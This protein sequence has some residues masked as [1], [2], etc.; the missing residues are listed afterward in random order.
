MKLNLD[1]KG[2][3]YI[4]FIFWNQIW[5]R[6]IKN[7]PGTLVGGEPSDRTFDIGA[8]RIRTIAYAQLSPRYLI[9]A[10]FGINNQTFTNGGGTVS[11]GT[12]ANG[13]GK[14]PQIFYHDVWNEYA[15][16]PSKN[17]VT[18]K[19]NKASLYAGAGLH[20]WN[21]ISRLTSASTLNFLLID[22]PLFNW[23]TL[24]ISD[25]FVRQFGFYAKGHAGKLH[26]RFNVNKPFA[27]N[28]APVAAGVAVDNNGD[29]KPAVGGYVDYQFLD[30]ENE[31]LPF[32]VG[33]YAG[34]K[35]VLNIG[36]GFYRTKDGTKSIIAENTIQKHDINIQAVDVFAD[37]P[38]GSKEK[39]MAITASS[40][41]Y[42]YDF[43]P[44][45]TRTI[46]LMNTGIVDPSFTGKRVQEGAGNARFLL[47]TGKIWYTQAG[48][49]LPKN[50]SSK[51][52]FQPVAAYTLKD[53]EAL[54]ELGHYYDIGSNFYIDGHN[55][56]ITLQYSSRP[57]YHN[58]KV[59][60][61]AGE[62][63]MQ[64]QIYL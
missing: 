32:R 64:F 4:R 33:T 46:G 23:P 14:K 12:G 38:F 26:Y 52:R 3:K 15:I 17:A 5:A 57:L 47:G 41:L 51:V 27:T 8:R 20:Y 19:A 6:S 61:R 54:E 24:E 30:Q 50:I 13:A 63:Q 60:T 62:W 44:N 40:T 48:I 11:A 39:N 21:G 16:I 1:E 7:N 22:A 36:A 9:M 35:K 43:G 58:K 59:F 29:P 37:L 49:M 10:H 28:T 55:A 45:Y 31:V 2:S 42:K 53:L 56:K 25:Q 34:T 18:G